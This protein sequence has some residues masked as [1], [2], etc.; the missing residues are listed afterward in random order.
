MKSIHQYQINKKIYNGINFLNAYF[1][2]IN[3]LDTY[4]RPCGRNSISLCG[5]ALEWALEYIFQDCQLGPFRGPQSIE[6]P[7]D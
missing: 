2:W 1:G 6:S 3:F 7:V 5:I 4:F